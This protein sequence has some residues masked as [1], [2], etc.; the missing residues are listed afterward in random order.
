MMRKLQTVIDRR[1]VAL[2]RTV[3]TCYAVG[4][5]ALAGAVDVRAQSSVDLAAL[6]AYFA[7]S[8]DVFK[9]PG[10]A[11]AIV[12][13]GELVFAKGYGLRELGKDE[14]VDEHTA[15]AIASNTKAFTSAALA[16]LVDEGKISWDDRDVQRRS[17]VVRHV[18]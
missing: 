18:V 5:L 6:D 3:L 16:I 12:K 8:G 10:F 9:V 7:Q 2:F 15:F 11:V 14:R 1:R 4:V 13:D 17:V